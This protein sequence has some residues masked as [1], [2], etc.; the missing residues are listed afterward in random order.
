MTIH[1]QLPAA[2]T[3]SVFPAA[4]FSHRI[5]LGLIGGSVLRAHSRLRVQNQ[6]D[7]GT[8]KSMANEGTV[9]WSSGQ[10][11]TKQTVRVVPPVVP[12]STVS[13]IL[14]EK[15]R[16]L[17]LAE[18]TGQAFPDISVLSHQSE[19]F[20]VTSATISDTIFT[21]TPTTGR[22]VLELEQEMLPSVQTGVTSDAKLASGGVPDVIPANTTMSPVLAR[23]LAQRKRDLQAN[24][25]QPAVHK[26]DSLV[27]SLL[28]ISMLGVMIIALVV[29]ASV[30]VPEVY[31]KVFPENI[32]EIAQKP[33]QIMELNPIEPAETPE[34]A[35]A[36]PEP[37]F[38]PTLPEGSWL[39]I[40]SIG[41]NTQL[42]DTMD[43][44]EALDQGAWLVPDFGRPNDSSLPIIAA[45]HRFGWDWWWKSDFGR[46]NSFYSL[47]DLASGDTVEI[48][49]NQRKY[50]YRVYSQEEGREITDYA[51]DLILYTC[52]FLNSPE[53]YFTYANRDVT[54]E[55]SGADTTLLSGLAQ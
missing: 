39:I 40:P 24:Y 36:M 35:L 9:L 15:P 25:R 27:K 5:G 14:P 31:Y 19:P 18:S 4:W 8:M 7:L 51:A 12:V 52:K 6:T 48:V 37:A 50:V 10:T 54:A 42:R 17:P 11:A 21:P 34:M 33:N 44:N 32:D 41:V 29:M 46:K 38:D 55:R 28:R 3:T 1:W 22:S 23:A 26:Q 13:P 16:V 47:P 2:S 49:F 43:P 45:A 53:R 30:V 20:D